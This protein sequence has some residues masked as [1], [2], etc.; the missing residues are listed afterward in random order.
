[1]LLLKFPVERNFNLYLFSDAHAGSSLFYRKGFLKFVNTV[2]KDKMGYAID[3]GDAIEAI[4][5]DD[6]RYTDDTA[7][8]PIPLK[9]AN[10]YIEMIRPIK[11][12][13]IVRLLGNHEHTLHRFGN[14][15]QHICTQLDIPYGTF[16][17]KV[18]F[19]DKKTGKLMFKA[20]VTHGFRSITNQAFDPIQ[21]EANVKARLK[22]LLSEKS[23]DCIL[24]AM[25][26]THKLI[27]AEP[28]KK[29]W[30][31]DDGMNIKQQYMNHEGNLYIHP[32]HRWTVNTGS[33]LKLYENGVS[34]YAEMYGY[35]PVELGYARV[36]VRKGEIE[37]VHKVIL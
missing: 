14:L 3:L 22:R 12:K 32:D 24:Q 7:K 5:S 23:G 10:D 27:V 9:Q 28:T 33:F 16:T 1:M 11:D 2:K 4:A 31:S 20:F 17:V 18:L 34:G 29:L 35:D 19:T 36:E 25:G 30:L 8:Q 21:R 13:I 15:A 6:K 26:H 37:N